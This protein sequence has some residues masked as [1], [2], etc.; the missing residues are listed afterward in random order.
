V[1]DY[2]PGNKNYKKEVD[3]NEIE[4]ANPSL[5]KF[6]NQYYEVPTKA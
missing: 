1:Q 5:L 3:I 2:T 4:K 6:N